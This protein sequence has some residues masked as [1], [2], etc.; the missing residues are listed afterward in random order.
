MDIKN[1]IDKVA[2]SGGS[3]LHL[4]IGSK[5]LIR[6]NKTL[7]QMDC[8]ALVEEDMNA[9]IK[10]LLS[11]DDF[12][13]L[14][15]N[16][17]FEANHFGQ[18]PCNFRLTMFH[19]QE[20]PVAFIKIINSKVP[21]LTEIRFPEL[22]TNALSAPKG[23]F[24]LA[25]PAHSGISTSLAAIVEH[26]NNKYRRHILVIEDP[27]EYNYESKGCVISQRQFSKDIFMIEQGINFAK[28]MDVDTLVIGDLKRDIPFKNIIEYVAGGHLVILCMQTLGIVNTLEKFVYSF[29]EQYREYV[30][31]AL[32]ENL[33]GLCS[34]ALIPTAKGTV[35]PVHEMLIPEK[36][37]MAI[38]AKG[39]VSQI[40][41]NM[42]NNGSE[43]FGDAVNQK[44]AKGEIDKPSGEAFLEFL[45]NSKA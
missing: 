20:K 41:P 6:K 44:I 15:K 19:S 32:S 5:P 8:P 14:Q 40:E 34:Q 1:L 33:L 38:I 29:A 30:W 16:G 7:K 2:T 42:A 9:L 45:R 17:I 27:I 21:S 35:V 18:P 25:G 23:L 36:N 43:K 39:K 11:D 3:E 26:M 31:Q 28:R 13:K 12:K 37:T 22:I 24:I 4:K 10:D